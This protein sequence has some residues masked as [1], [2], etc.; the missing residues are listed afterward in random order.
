MALNEKTV[1]SAGSAL[2][3]LLVRVDAGWPE[4]RGTRPG[5][6]VNVDAAEI[7]AMLA[8]IPAAPEQVSGGSACNTIVGLSFLGAKC[9]FLGC[10]GDDAR[11]EFFAASLRS[12][13]VEGSLVRVEG[14][15]TGTCLSVITPDAQ[16]S[17]FTA[18]EVSGRLAPEHL[19]DAFFDSA[20]LLHLEGYLAFNAPAFRRVVAMA[21]ERGARISLDLSA[22]QCVEA[23]GD[24][25]AEAMKNVDILIANEDEAKAFTGKSAGEALEVMARMAPLAVVKLGAEGARVARGDRRVVSRGIPVEAVDTTGA[26]DLWASGFLAGVLS[27]ETL[28]SAADFANLVGSEIVRVVGAHLPRETWERLVR[29]RN[30]ARAG[31]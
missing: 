10:V 6:M 7:D 19:S 25:F 29:H 4:R 26:G 1:V 11:G 18:L 3:D 27:G 14:A 22:W 17:M 23:C 8:E 20:D 16:R 24:L 31:L 5:G 28:Q 13:G 9:R 15:R 30:S 12:R 21:A 2:V